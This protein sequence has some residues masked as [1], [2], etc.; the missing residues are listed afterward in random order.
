MRE[1]VTTLDIG[2][3]FRQFASFYLQRHQLKEQAMWK[4]FLAEKHE[5]KGTHSTTDTVS[6]NAMKKM[7]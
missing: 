2:I 6:E 5:E 4:S 3:L 7:P 1:W